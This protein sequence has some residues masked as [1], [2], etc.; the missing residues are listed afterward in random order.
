MENSSGRNENQIILRIQ[1][2]SEATGSTS[3][4]GRYALKA[5]RGDGTRNTGL[6]SNAAGPQEAGQR[7][8]QVDDGVAASQW[9]LDAT[10]RQEQDN[11]VKSEKG[12]FRR[13]LRERAARGKAAS[14]A[15][16]NLFIL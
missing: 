6:L 2:L 12:R 1:G 11:N 15:V 16:S 7:N 13:M 3:G 4:S 14:A 5:L 8:Y 9:S 10:D